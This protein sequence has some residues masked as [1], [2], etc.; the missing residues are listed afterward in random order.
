MTTLRQAVDRE[1]LP[2]S[3]LFSSRVEIDFRAWLAT[4]DGKACLSEATS[5]ALRLRERGF[6]HYGIGAICEAMRFDSS[7]HL[8]PDVDGFKLNNNH[9]AHLAREIVK[10]TPQLAGFFE[11]RTLRGRFR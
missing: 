11:T 8:G 7:L 9:R 6:H 5:R 1:Q 4:E 3:D 10:S 2:L